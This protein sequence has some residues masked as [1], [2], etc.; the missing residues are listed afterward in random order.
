[1]F[2]A[3]YKNYYIVDEQGRHTIITDADNKILTFGEGE[4]KQ[5]WNDYK[6]NAVIFS[7]DCNVSGTIKNGAVLIEN[8]FSYKNN[9][10][11]IRN[12]ETDLAENGFDIHNNGIIY[13]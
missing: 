1:M 7:S 12:K 3:V 9:H 2:E 5:S 13:S 10:F 11:I 6:G 4:N 8:T